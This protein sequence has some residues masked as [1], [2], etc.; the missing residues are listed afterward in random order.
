M[1]RRH[2]KRR[3]TKAFVVSLS[4]FLLAVLFRPDAPSRVPVSQPAS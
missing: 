2:A 1:H 4:V 3:L